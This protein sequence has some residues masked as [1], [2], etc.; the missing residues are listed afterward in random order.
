MIKRVYDI[1]SFTFVAF[2]NNYLLI[3]TLFQEEQLS[4]NGE[5]MYAKNW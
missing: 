1:F 5:R 4:V 2:E 3:K